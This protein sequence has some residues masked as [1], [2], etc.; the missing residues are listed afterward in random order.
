MTAAKVS[1]HARMKYNLTG[2]TFATTTLAE[3]VGPGPDV[4]G[5]IGFEMNGVNGMMT[6]LR[7]NAHTDQDGR[8]FYTRCSWRE[9]LP[10]KVAP[11]FCI[12]RHKNEA[13]S[14]A[15]WPIRLHRP[16]IADNSRRLPGFSF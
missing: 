3:G 10:L 14:A 1:E 13:G 15:N 7:T 8:C 9:C 16:R 12:M 11:S 2:G 6:N 5:G 4:G